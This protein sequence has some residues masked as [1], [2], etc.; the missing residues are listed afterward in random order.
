MTDKINGLFYL[1]GAALNTAEF[2]AALS[3]VVIDLFMPS[4]APQ[5]E[6]KQ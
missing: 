5:E 6:L 2:I 4:L 1:L 3:H